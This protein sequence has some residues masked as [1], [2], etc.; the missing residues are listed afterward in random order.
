MNTFI[1]H[2]RD[3]RPYEI[4]LPS[5]KDGLRSSYLFAFAKSGSTLLDNMISTYCQRIGVPCFSLFNQAFGQ[6]I[7]TADVGGDALVCFKPRGYVY[8]GF[9]HYPGF[10]LPLAGLTSVLLVRDPRDMLV[11][12]Y[13]SVAKSHV[14]PDGNKLLQERR[15]QALTDTIDEFVI[16]R[17]QR[18]MK[19]YRIYKEKLPA[20]AKVYRYEDV[21]FDKINWMDDLVRT[22]EL[23]LDRTIMKEVVE[24]FDIVPDVEDET[25]HI[26]QVLPGNHRKKLMPGTIVALDECLHYFLKEYGYL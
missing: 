1:L 25:R 20:S 6:G 5:P 15:K 4:K 17:A 9:R 22:L 13:Y 12:L 19:Q 14:I 21:V 8:T 26:R 10:D 3:N 7:V 24:Q 11:S 2:S 18:Y 16:K 23:E